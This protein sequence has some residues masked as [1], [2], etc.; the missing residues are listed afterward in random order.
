MGAGRIIKNLIVAIIIILI[1]LVP[2]VFSLYG[3]WLWFQSVGYNQVFLTMLFTSV[4]LGLAF[5]I[6]FL[7]FTLLNLKI[8]SR[9]VKGKKSLKPFVLLTLVL[10]LAMG[11]SLSGWE[12]YL[13]FSNPTEFGVTDPVFGLD[14]SFYVFTL[15]WYETLAGFAFIT[16]L[17]SIALTLIFYLYS[18]VDR[19]KV[20]EDEIPSTSF[21]WKN[22]QKDATSHMTVLFGL[23]FIIIAFGFYI[24][25]F[26]L[27]L[28]DTGAAFGAGYTDVNI[29]LPLLNLLSIVSGIVGL[30]LIGNAFIGRWRFIIEGIAVVF[31]IFIIGMVVAGLTQALYVEPDELTIEQPFIERNIQYTLKAYDLEGI[32]E[33]PFGLGNI[34]LQDIEANRETI[35][36]IRLWD[37]R[38]LGTTYNQLQLFRTYYNFN[39]IDIDRYIVNGSPRQVMI[40]ARE[41]N[42]GNLQSSA[43]TWINEHMVYT[44]GYGIVMNPV[45]MI[46]EEGLPEFFIQDIPP[47]SNIDVELTRPEIYYGETEGDYAIIKTTTE[48]LDYPSGSENIYTEYAG[49]GGIQLDAFKRLVY[50]IQF[51]S[52]ELFFSG[53][54]TPESKLLMKRNIMERV[55]TIAPFIYYDSDPYIVTVDGKLYWMID[56][57]SITDRYPYSQPAF[58]GVNYIRNSVKIVVDAYNGDVTYYVMDKEPVLETYMKIFP[59][60]F[61]DFSEMP[62]S[63]KEH[64]RYPED[65]FVIQ[66]DIYSTYH[67]KDPRVF[68]NKED[69]W[70]TPNEV[71]RGS[72]QKMIPYYVI[73][74]LPGEEKEEFIMMIPFT[75]RGKDNLI[76]WMA[77]KSDPEEYGKT[78]VFTFSKQEL[79]FGPMQIE[80]RIDQDTEISQLITLW[81]Q[82]GSDVFRGNTLVIP[83]ENAILYV[84]PLFLQ[85][86]GQGTL[87]ELKRVIVAH[88][89]R[90]SMQPT[91]EEAL[92]G[93]FGKSTPSRPDQP[94][95][96]DAEKIVEIK[97]LYDKAQAALRA[98]DLAAYANYMEQIGEILT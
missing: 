55:D 74:K 71:L 16:V 64:I 80:A 4:Y 79:Q 78:I 33:K 44:H 47:Q 6:G 26:S 88:G 57:Y 95:V 61:K 34:T 40:S 96:T 52:V 46:S 89:N 8:A 35:D 59:G 87:P 42:T 24:S 1:V 98:G 69:V 29:T 37:F 72:T 7:I 92:V 75:P 56:A 91:L 53:S 32:E 28:S 85:A 23:L 45:N 36:N 43:R 70:I 81:S 11:T 27:L 21:N 68:Y 82:A 2:I 25:Q 38:P 66:K 49:S 20:E 12:P 13:K 73:M 60:M 77:T 18:S 50:A 39:D 3:D 15:P 67:M 94:A 93:I 10:S 76:G 48:E 51:A 83:I 41:M 62:S 17:L 22:L 9:R 30:L 54:I 14:T 97:S 58:Y 19:K 5:G 86:T 84:E 63:L 31:A 65:L 90:I